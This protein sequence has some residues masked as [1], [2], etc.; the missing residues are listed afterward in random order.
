MYRLEAFASI[1]Y[2]FCTLIVRHVKKPNTTAS[3]VYQL[4]HKRLAFYQLLK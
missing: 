1:A 4:G 3:A 2:T